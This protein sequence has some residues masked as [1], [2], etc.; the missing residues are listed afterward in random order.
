MTISYRVHRTRG[1]EGR[2]RPHRASAP[3]ALMLIGLTACGPNVE[4]QPTVQEWMLGTFSS[5]EPEAWTENSAVQHYRFLEGMEAERFTSW[6]CGSEADYV[7]SRTWEPRT[8][9]SLAM[10]PQEGEAGL[11]HVLEYIVRPEPG[12]SVAC[13]PYEVIE[14]RRDGTTAPYSPIIRGEVCA[15]D[16]PPCPH[17]VPEDCEGHLWEPTE[18]CGWPCGGSELVQQDEPPPGCEDPSD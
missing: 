9:D 10:F 12:A 13:G 2:S 14:V 8:S 18:R 3:A 11:M 4:E 5:R 15:R 17:P 7:A 1:D 16:Y 6:G